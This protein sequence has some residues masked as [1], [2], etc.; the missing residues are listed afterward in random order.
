MLVGHSRGGRLA[1]EA[2]AFLKPRLVIAFFP[3]LINVQMEPPTN[4]KLIPPTTDI[5]VFVG[6]KDTS[7][8]NS[9][10]IEL[11]DRLLHFGFPAAGSTVASSIQRLASRPT[12]CRCTR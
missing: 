6:D 2:A 8:G 5:Y 9:G 11:D 4:F 10:A 3:G 7:V 12:T 1:A